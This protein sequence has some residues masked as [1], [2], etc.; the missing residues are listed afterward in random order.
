MENWKV[1]WGRREREKE[2]N[3]FLNRPIVKFF[4]KLKLK[5]KIRESKIIRKIYIFLRNVAT[6]LLLK[7]SFEKRFPP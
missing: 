2:R 4:S 7:L 1:A 3:E 6:I 5:L